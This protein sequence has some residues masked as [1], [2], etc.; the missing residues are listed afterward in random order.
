VM[1]LLKLSISLWGLLY[2]RIRRVEDE[3]PDTIVDEQVA[4]VA[5]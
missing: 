3:L 4:V 5:M 2:P 1:G